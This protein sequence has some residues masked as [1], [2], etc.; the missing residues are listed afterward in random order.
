MQLT[1]RK[2]IDV[3]S[4]K[5]QMYFNNLTNVSTNMSFYKM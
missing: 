3:Q 2:K 5:N 4:I 1:I